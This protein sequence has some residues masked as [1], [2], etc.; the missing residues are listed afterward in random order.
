MTDL[1]VRFHVH[2]FT[3][4]ANLQWESG[5]EPGTLQPL[6]RDLTTRPPRSTLMVGL[7]RDEPRWQL[8]LPK[9]P[10]RTNVPTD[11]IYDKYQTHMHGVSMEPGLEPVLRFAML[12]LT[13]ILSGRTGAL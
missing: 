2:Q 6:S 10:H 4:P 1:D 13:L 12:P 5:F 7:L 9:F 8:S 3:Y 11:G